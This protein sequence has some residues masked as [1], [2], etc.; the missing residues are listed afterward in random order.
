MWAQVH[1]LDGGSELPEEDYSPGWYTIEELLG[2]I[3]VT[4]DPRTGLEVRFDAAIVTGTERDRL[5]AQLD[6]AALE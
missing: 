3:F 5:W 1:W 2:G 4:C 6:H